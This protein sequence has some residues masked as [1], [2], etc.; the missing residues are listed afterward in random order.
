MML[1]FA[2]ISW[3]G[4]PGTNN[5]TDGRGLHL[6]HYIAAMKFDGNLTNAEVGDVPADVEISG[7][8]LLALS[9]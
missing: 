6:P 5:F 8:A 7:A 9:R 2:L 4:F 1:H 3:Q